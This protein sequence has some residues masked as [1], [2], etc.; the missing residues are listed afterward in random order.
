MVLMGIVAFISSFAVSYIEQMNNFACLVRLASGNSKSSQAQPFIGHSVAKL[1]KVW[2][3]AKKSAEKVLGLF[4]IAMKKTRARQLWRAL[5]VVLCGG[6]M[7]WRRSG[8]RP[9]PGVPARSC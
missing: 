7:P 8:G 2:E 5:V 9:L 6:F 3:V 4:R 1:R